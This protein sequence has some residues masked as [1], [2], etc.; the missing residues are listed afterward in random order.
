MQVT[1]IIAPQERS[2]ISVLKSA[3]A[4]S[5]RIPH[6]LSLVGM[7]SV[8]TG[9]LATPALTTIDFPAEEMGRVAARMLLERLEGKQGVAE[10]VLVRPELIVR[11]TTAPPSG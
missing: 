1:A 7:L 11:G 10:Q 4:R 3:Q 9:E 5:I 6:D 2:V 8:S